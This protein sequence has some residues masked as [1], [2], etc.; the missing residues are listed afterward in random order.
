VT[1]AK[2]TR[3]ERLTAYHEAGH[4]VV[5]HLCG[6]RVTR[7]EIVGDAEHTGACHSLTFPPERNRP[8]DP[9]LPNVD[10]EARILCT[11]AGI[12]AES[13]VTGDTGWD[14]SSEDL[15]R[16]VRLSIRLLGDCSRVVR[17]LEAVRSHAEDLL[18]YNWSSVEA[19]AAALMQRKAL[20]EGEIQDVLRRSVA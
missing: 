19:L 17:Y 16:A 2:N 13:I 1:L 18:R 8:V 7:L 4:A 10:L 15:D 5:A 12:V 6:R 9:A 14:E 3:V 11:C 20:N